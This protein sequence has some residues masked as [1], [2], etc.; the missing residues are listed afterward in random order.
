M[1][2]LCL[3]CDWDFKANPDDRGTDDVGGYFCKWCSGDGKVA[4]SHEASGAK[5]TTY[6]ADQEKAGNSVG[7]A[8]ARKGL[9][10]LEVQWADG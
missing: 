10:A 3:S 4:L 9:D 1:V 6:L 7:H 5:L 2:D 8:E